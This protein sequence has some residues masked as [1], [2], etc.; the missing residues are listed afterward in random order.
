MT[1]DESG[2]MTREETSC[3]QNKSKE[4]IVTISPMQSF[5]KKKCFVQSCC[6]L[7][8][9]RTLWGRRISARLFMAFLRKK[10]HCRDI[11]V[12]D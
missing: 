2:Q 9:C 7:C 8:S 4:S 5:K 12:A 1:V 6:Y 10:K 11:S 3:V